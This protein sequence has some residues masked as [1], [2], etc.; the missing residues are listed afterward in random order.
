[1]YL[2]TKELHMLLGDIYSW[3]KFSLGASVFKP[4][5]LNCLTEAID[6]ALKILLFNLN[7]NRT[8]DSTKTTSNI[9]HNL[10]KREHC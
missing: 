5:E 3:L 6:N 10:I 8:Q 7:E 2:Y 9:V 1:M 4:N